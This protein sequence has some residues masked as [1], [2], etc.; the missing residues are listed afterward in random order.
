MATKKSEATEVAEQVTSS[1]HAMIERMITSHERF[2][3]ALTVSR[4]RTSR[5]TDKFFEIVLA[6]QRD[7]IELGKSMSVD[8]S[9]YGKNMEAIMHSL[10]TAQE[11]ALDLAKTVYQEQTEAATE[12]RALAERALEA[13]KTL[14]KP[15][16]K[17]NPLLAAASK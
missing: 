2:T 4:A 14:A 12:A 5:M 17:F 11:R 8:P 10:T 15:F 13:S 7:A 16:E 3:E 6:G 9:A 1:A